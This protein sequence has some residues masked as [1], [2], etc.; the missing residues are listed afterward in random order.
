MLPP[1]AAP[2]TTRAWPG[3]AHQGLLWLARPLGIYLAS[4]TVVVAALGVAAVLHPEW[5]FG[6]LLGHWD[7]SWYRRVAADGYPAVV[8]TG[9][10][11]PA[12]Q[13][14]VAFFPLFPL[15][16]RF[17]AGATGLSVTAAGVLLAAGFGALAAALLWELV[18]REAGADV[19]DRATALFCFF[20]AAAVLS[21]NYAE[22]LLLALAIGCL[23]ALR[24]QQWLLAGVTAGLATATRPNAVALVACC[25]WEAGRR[26]RRREWRALAAPLLAPA[27][28]LV[29]FAF[30][31]VRTGDALVWLHVQAAGWD[32]H[33]DFGRS[34]I[35]GVLDTLRHPGV[36]LNISVGAASFVFAVVAGVLLVRS[37][38][39]SV[40][41]VYSAVVLALAFSSQAVGSRPRFVLTA[42][43][44]IVAVARRA[45]GPAFLIVL[46]SSAVL[47]AALTVL[48]FGAP[49]D[50]AP[51]P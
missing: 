43:P 20:P 7:S 28:L 41:V 24:R 2:P 12:N 49:P 48:S 23:L 40:F 14:T 42:F 50:V 3:A 37:R 26:L 39:P 17:L 27:G 19:A 15:L 31:W 29:F 38:L 10:G 44:L 4:R 46:G 1:P 11:L 30:L 22:S 33:V 8:P 25:A 47:L 13:S 51:I 36:H 9:E 32:Q 18:R 34:T 45:R 5:N 16:T 21:L 6:F 35:Q